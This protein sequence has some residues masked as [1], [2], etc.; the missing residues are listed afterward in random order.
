MNLA[1]VEIENIIIEYYFGVELKSFSFPLGI[2]EVREMNNTSKSKLPENMKT[3]PIA[4]GITMKTIV[5][6]DAN[7]NECLKYDKGYFSIQ[8]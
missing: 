7:E 3:D 5:T 8:F 6:I 2:Y 1:C 4:E